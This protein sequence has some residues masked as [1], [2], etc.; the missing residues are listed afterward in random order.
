VGKAGQP[1][2]HREWLRLQRDDVSKA[3]A[4]V[5][6]VGAA[7]RNRVQGRRKFP[8]STFNNWLELRI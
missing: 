4:K 8:Q 5:P 6:G 1:E 3:G 2:L 7:E